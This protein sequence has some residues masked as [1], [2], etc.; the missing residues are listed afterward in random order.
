MSIIAVFLIFSMLA[1]LWFDTT[2]YIIPNWLVGGL[3][4]AYPLAVLMAP[5][6]VD[7]PMALAA[8][9]LTLVL[10][11]IVF[12]LRLMGGGDVKLIAVLAIW[13]G[14]AGLAD[15]IFSVAIL[16]GVLSGLLWGGRKLLVKLPKLKLEKLPRILREGAPVP[17]GIAIALGFLLVLAG[18]KVAVV[19]L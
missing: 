15:F 7:W 18:G 17:Y 9:G 2:R 13:V 5:N 12:T 1:V 6:P 8:G 19:A 16:G 14:F 10:G 4:A 3:L 11:Y